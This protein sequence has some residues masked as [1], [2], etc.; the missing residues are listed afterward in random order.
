MLG[1]SSAPDRDVL[2]LLS[3]QE[4]ARADAFAVAS[5]RSTD[6]LMQ[7]AGEAVAAAI[8][9]RWS[10]RKVLV[11]CG[12]GNNG[13]DGFVAAR[14]L[15]EAGW[16]VRVALLGERASLKGAAA[17][18]AARW[19]GPVAALS[20]GEIGDAELLVDA[21]FG[22]GLARPVTGVAAETLA[23]V[24]ASGIPVAAVDIPS[25]VDGAT[26]AV[27]GVAA[28]ADL[29]VT[30]FRKK[31]G[32]LLLPG[33][34]LC[35]DT[36]VAD[37]GI[38]AA[39]LAEIAPTTHENGPPLWLDRYPWP[40]LEDH[41]YRRGHAL[42][43][44]GETMTG[45]AR[46]AARAAGRMGAGLVTL[47]APH[48]A[49]PVYASA[50]ISVIVRSIGGIEDFKAMLEDPRRNVILLGPGGGTAL[51]LRETVLAALA[52]RRSV[53][54]DADALTVFADA[55]T[56]LMG[57]I[58]GPTVLTPHEGEFARLFSL[59]GNKLARAR[60]AAASSRAVVV[61]KGPDT[62]VAAPDGRAIINANAP[63]DLASGGTG[64]VLAGMITGLLAQGMDAF[65][66]AA[67][68]V[69]LHGEAGQAVGP[70]LIAEDLLAVLPGILRG[71]KGLA[72][73][74]GLLASVTDRLYREP[75]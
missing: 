59:S 21:I 23:A 19:T 14:V 38:P 57:A 18:H 25:G 61:L 67:A 75:E 32:H 12:P 3:P 68:A 17:H 63:P 66:A 8:A 33:R 42:V 20:P 56:A 50:L 10:P 6:A 45:A 58:A 49:W 35:G 41:K 28:A 34:R 46:L 16:P 7:A 30:F 52:T 13:G 24:A 40:K 26:G 73:E 37:I 9:A 55:P 27:R 31:P 60:A 15:R 64:D 11:A 71:L 53:V 2:A 22:A 62:V 39:A 51:A 1:R 36:A 5:G 70:G 74:R 69:W 48:S 29:T 47:A 65:A 54:L 43:A 4:M 72:M 44:G